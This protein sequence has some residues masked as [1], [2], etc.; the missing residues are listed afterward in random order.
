[1]RY[2]ARIMS[3]P[4]AVTIDEAL[5]EERFVR[6]PGP[7]GQNVNKVATAVQLRY[8]TTQAGLTAEVRH[9]LRLIAGTQ[10]TRE[11]HL[12]I[13]ANRFRS[14]T[15]NR[16]DARERLLALLKRAHIRPRPRIATAPTAAS[17]ERRLETKRRRASLKRV[18][19]A[20]DREGQL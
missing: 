14:Q 2:T 9:R 1:M 13:Q 3:N 20:T 4:S 7:G 6:A 16:A 10:M 15:Q 18:R 17:R 5:I 19:R 12:L 11:G 8:D